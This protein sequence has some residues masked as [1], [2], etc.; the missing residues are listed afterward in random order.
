[1]VRQDADAQI[2]WH[3]GY[4]SIGINLWSCMACRFS[5]AATCGV[6]RMPEDLSP[7]E[8]EGENDNHTHELFDPC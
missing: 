7:R 8:Q 2:L 6:K 4:T 5:E 1:M 3:V